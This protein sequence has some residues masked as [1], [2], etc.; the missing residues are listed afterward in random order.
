MNSKWIEIFLSILVHSLF[1]QCTWKTIQTN[2]HTINICL[3]S[4]ANRITSAASSLHAGVLTPIPKRQWGPTHW[5]RKIFGICMSVC[6]FL[7]RDRS[8]RNY[9]FRLRFWINV[10]ILC[11]I[12][13]RVFGVHYP[14]SACTRMHINI[15][16]HLLPTQE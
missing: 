5:T 8:R 15:S 3:K 10:Y 16:I 6:L 9:A 11:K 4:Q 7:W 12:T 14:N 13:C 1:G 2:L